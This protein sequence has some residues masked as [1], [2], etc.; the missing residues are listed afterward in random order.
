MLKKLEIEGY[1]RKLPRS[2][3]Q[4]E[5]SI[6]LAERDLEFARSILNQNYDWAFNIAYNSILQA[7]RALMYSK[8]YRASSRNSH[9]ATLKFAEIYLEESDILYFDRMRRKRHK[10]VYD[11]AGAI[12]KTEAENAVLKSGKILD[13]VKKLIE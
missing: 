13:K 1:I 2:S 12:S 11:V 5:E 8:G 4:V 3:K 9:I 6:K 7:F 10:S